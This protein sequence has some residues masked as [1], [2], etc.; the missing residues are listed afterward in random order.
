MM[1]S[2]PDTIFRFLPDTSDC[3]DIVLRIQGLKHVRSIEFDSINQQIYWIDD[4][5]LSIRKTQEN[6]TYSSIIVSEKSGDP[7]DLALDPLGRLLFWSCTIN[8]AINVIKLDNDSALGI[9]VKGD[10]EKPSISQYIL[11]RDY[12]SGRTL[13]GRRG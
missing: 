12:F 13:E 2:L 5:T 11:K 8:D 3:P 1:Y 9:V 10:G 6:R 4:Q 7:V